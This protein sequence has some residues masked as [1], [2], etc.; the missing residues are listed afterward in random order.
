[1]DSAMQLSCFGSSV[2]RNL[3]RVN[4]NFD[5]VVVLLCD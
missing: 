1:M 5:F 4:K 2:G 3:E